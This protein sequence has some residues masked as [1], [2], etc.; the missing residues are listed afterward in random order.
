MDT[1]TH[2]LVGA[3]V[4]RSFPTTNT[5]IN[6]NQR[7]IVGAISAAFPDIDYLT[8]WLDP[9]S[10][11]S[12][13]HRGPTHSLVLLPIWALLL[14]LLWSRVFNRP[15]ASRQLI[16][17]AAL[18]LGSQILTDIITV[19]G[20]GI[21]YPI[22]DWRPG[23]GTT[24]VV[25]P[26]LTMLLVVALCGSLLWGDT[27]LPRAGLLVL[28]CALGI[29][30]FLH[31]AA[32][33]VGRDYASERGLDPD[34]VQAIAQPLS[35]LHWKIVV[36]DAHGYRTAHIRLTERAGF[37][38][39]LADWL[40]VDMLLHAYRAT[41]EADWQRHVLFDDS[42]GD[43]GLVRTV[44]QHPLLSRFRRFAAMPVLYRIDRSANGLCVW[45]TDLRF[46]LPSLF[47]AFRYGLC[48][49]GQDGCPWRLYRIRRFTDGDIDPV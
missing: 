29:H 48:R 28:V 44:W 30:I 39:V 35:P 11:L 3:L 22:L 21:F 15:E 31:R 24:F 27:L 19:Y 2:A 46:T 36:P 43:G 34:A 25:D 13:W 47:P 14:G 16:L 23:L 7:M 1:L 18:A 9:L 5:G 12:D 33:Q 4:G 38:P 45:F 17:I 10:F 8:F 26:W 40:G 42:L 41:D 6:A 20:T 32:E 37:P 49:T